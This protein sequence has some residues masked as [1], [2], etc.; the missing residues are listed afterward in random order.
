[1]SAPVRN[2]LPMSGSAASALLDRVTADP[3][4][5][6]HA[7]V[8]APGGYGKTALLRRLAEVYRDAGVPVAGPWPPV[9]PPADH[10]LLIDDAHLLAPD[11]LDELRGHAEHPGARIVVAH[12]PWPRRP[13]LLR[14]VEALRRGGPSVALPA[15]TT[16]Q[17]AAHLTARL[18]GP[19][20]AEL[21]AFVAAQTAGIPRY[22]TRIADALAAGPPGQPHVP[23]AALAGFA[24]ELDELEPGVRTLLLAVEAG[25]GLSFDLMAAVL[26]T[27]AD[28]DGLAEAGRSTGMLAPDGSLVP[29]ARRAIA[30]LGPISQRIDVRQRL[31]ARQLA[32]GGPVLP[33][34]RPLLR[35]ATG[36]GLVPGAA[37][38]GLGPVYEAA[39]EEALGDDP[40]LA[41]E[42]FEAAAGAG[43]T[44]AVRR[45]LAT[46]LAGDLDHASRLTDQVLSAGTPGQRAEAAYVAA[47]VLAYRG[48]TAQSV[49]L[50]AWA[51]SDVA[52]GFA[53]VGLIATGRLPDAQRLIRPDDPAAQ[54]PTSLSAAATLMARGTAESV[55]SPSATALSTLVQAATLIGPA[56]PSALL[57]DSP[58]AV[59]ALLAMHG[60]DLDV[61]DSLLARAERH[62][63]GG[64]PL[65]ARHHLLSTWVLLLRGRLDEV[66]QRLPATAGVTAPEGRDNLFG[67]ALRVGLARRNSDLVGLRSAW[68]DACQALI[69]QPVELFNL[70][71]LGELAVAAARLGEFHRVAGHLAEADRLLAALGDPPL[72]TVLLHW[73]RLQAAILSDDHDTARRHADHLDA[74]R[75]AGPFA[76]AYADAALVW[77]EVLAGRIDPEPVLS[78]ART[79]SLA[80]LTWDAARLA[81]QA[82]IRTA[83]RKA[84]ALL[85]ESARAMQDRGTRPEHAASGTPG[86]A[87][88]AGQQLLSA[89]EREVGAL[90]LAGMT[91]KQ[92]AGR[93]YLSAKT[94][95]HHMARIRQ[96]LGCA[97]RHELLSRLREIIGDP[98][99]TA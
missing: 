16:G 1:M 12:R 71:P 61:A 72:W 64:A 14:L 28:I 27:G 55:T 93:L 3:S 50:F 21:I 59:G 54:P 80:G 89:R 33:L 23:V 43:R 40:A 6:M 39:G 58:E 95:E 15:L 81:G 11:R 52:A 84:M 74:A 98:E 79:L 77:L 29:L 17:I 4:A 13:V 87:V 48:Q 22:V 41:A 10:V 85:L 30:A 56:G 2:G 86:R 76:A 60:N 7:V 20:S 18:P 53:A 49:R 51:G 82:A 70:L 45:A 83:D 34:V 69:G 66:E 47:A 8:G 24:A 32:R 65:S 78:A 9:P 25:A 62:G 63:T 36:P 91:Y 90:V 46:A 19:P 96:R 94:V 73:Y 42:L 75:T 31:A 99:T 67:T 5:P 35:V 88:A 92:I 97:D 37:G 26:D 44:T 38:S 57:P 68:P